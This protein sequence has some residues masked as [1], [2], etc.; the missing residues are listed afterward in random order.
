M[1]WPPASR[2]A[3]RA[4]TADGV[5]ISGGLVIALV[6]RLFWYRSRWLERSQRRIG[7]MMKRVAGMRTN[8]SPEAGSKCR[9]GIRAERMVCYDLIMEMIMLKMG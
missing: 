3:T 8:G 1:R 5:T 6:T 9:E 2:L 7:V 4:A